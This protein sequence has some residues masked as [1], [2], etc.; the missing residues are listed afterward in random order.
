MKKV[1][2]ILLN[3]LLLPGVGTFVQGRWKQGILQTSLSL[4]LLVGFVAIMGHVA[5]H[6]ESAT[7]PKTNKFLLSGLLALFTLTLANWI[8]SLK[9]SGQTPPEESEG[10]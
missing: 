8:W 5:I 3:T 9:T 7:D 6:P 1:L 4:V 2:A 10:T